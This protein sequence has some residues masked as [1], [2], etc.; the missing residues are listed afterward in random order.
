MGVDLDAAVIADSRSAL[1][2]EADDSIRFKDR[3]SLLESRL[4][5]AEARARDLEQQLL[6]AKTMANRNSES[7][8]A[9]N[10]ALEAHRAVIKEL[11]DGEAILDA[12]DR[13]LDAYQALII[14]A[15]AYPEKVLVLDEAYKSAKQWGKVDMEDVWLLLRS[16]PALWS[17]HFEESNSLEV[18][19]YKATEHELALTETG[20]TKNDPE[21]IKQRRRTYD[22]S[23]GKKRTAV[24]WPHIKGKDNGFRIHYIAD[25][26]LK[27]IVIGHCG[28]HLKT[29]RSKKD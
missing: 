20:P 5:E 8:Y 17:I 23:D 1:S 4:K 29:S 6:V 25:H 13:S 26:D 2:F 11:K 9:L 16:I 12:I 27:K 3:L 22:V 24:F 7:V 18:A 14:I 10:K 19:Y 28:Q 15:E 21:C